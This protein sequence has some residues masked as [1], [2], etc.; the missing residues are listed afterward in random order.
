MSLAKNAGTALNA[1]ST[2][3]TMTVSTA[4]RRPCQP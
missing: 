1:D 3:V 4:A 2:R